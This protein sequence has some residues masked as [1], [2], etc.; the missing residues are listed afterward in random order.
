MEV[1]S[2]GAATTPVDI[3]VVGGGINGTGIARDLA[4]R[5][6]SVVLCEQSDLASAT[7]QWSSKLIHGGLRYLEHN[8][9]L[10]VRKALM[11]RE[12]LMRAAPHLIRPLRFVM[13]H[14]PQMRP[15]WLIRLGLFLYDHLAR[16]RFLPGSTGVD[17]REDPSGAPLSARFSRGFVYSDGFVDDARLVVLNAVDAREHGA[18]I[19]TRTRCESA[20]AED[21]VWTARLR[22]QGGETIEVHARAIVN[23][24]GPWADRFNAR[25]LALEDAGRLRLVKGSHIVVR[26]LFEHDHAYIFQ[27]DDG[28]IIFAIPFQDHFTLIGTTDVEY[29]GDP[30]DVAIDAAE[31]TYLCEQANRYFKHQL[32]ADDVV[33]TYSGVRPLLEDEASEAAAVTRD[34]RLELSMPGAPLLTVWGGKLTTYR[35]LSEEAADTLCRQLGCDRPAWT[36]A[37]PL[38]GGDLQ[39]PGKLVEQAVA[40]IEGL[41]DAV[42]RA[43]PQQ[44]GEWVGRICRAYG[45]RVWSWLGE[46]AQADL[47]REVAPGLFEA[48][49]RYLI[50][51]EWARSADD[52]LWRRTKLGLH[53]DSAQRKAVEEW[54]AARDE[55]IRDA[56]MTGVGQPSPGDAP[57]ASLR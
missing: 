48:E 1:S 26:K 37:Q 41:I 51:H 45:R 32:S 27:N 24:A 49:L 15:A 55:A 47:G 38:P 28:R 16:R 6:L 7:S 22:P 17:L 31:I 42:A 44:P 8:E 20:Q 46:T 14:N 2:R 30:K 52:V 4:G 13:P 10:L 53:L 36:D 50:E 5:G 54:M 11:E 23:A 34:Y 18:R 35:K 43:R 25:G 12:V 33:W 3:L 21:G 56:T 39:R 19:L 9:F 40:A 29:E 57:A